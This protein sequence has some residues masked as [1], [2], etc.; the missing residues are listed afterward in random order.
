MKNQCKR[1]DNRIVWYRTGTA[2]WTAS[3]EWSSG[4]VALDADDKSRTALMAD[5]HYECSACWV[6]MNHTLAYHHRQLEDYLSAH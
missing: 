4:V 1:I 6:G 2:G 3:G 5:Y